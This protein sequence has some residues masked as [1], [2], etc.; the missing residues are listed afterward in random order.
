MVLSNQ[1]P[2]VI[3]RKE[4]AYLLRICLTTFDR[5]R[6]PC[7]KIGRRV[8]YRKSTLESWISSQEQ[9]KEVHE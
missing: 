4:A 7:F 2:E 5:L 3:T 6:L 1:T 9:T 8:Y